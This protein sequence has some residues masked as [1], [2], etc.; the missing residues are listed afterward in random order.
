MMFI[1]WDAEGDLLEIRF[2]KPTPA[3]YE[4]M[5]ED[6]FKRIEEETGK[7]VG[8]ALFNVK[9]RKDLRLQDIAVELPEVI[10]V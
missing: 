6:I 3:Y 1:H 4:E 7:V 8:Y 9:K 5:G 10:A 2:S